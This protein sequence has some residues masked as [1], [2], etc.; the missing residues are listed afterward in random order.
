MQSFSD[1]KFKKTG[2]LRTVS[3]KINNS[4]AT[5]TV[6]Y[7][8]TSFFSQEQSLKLQEKK[9]VENCSPCNYFPITNSIGLCS[10]LTPKTLSFLNFIV[11]RSTYICP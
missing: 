7:K 10:T 2:N 5:E 6:G 4:F 11:R 1:P 8:P 3:I 9:A